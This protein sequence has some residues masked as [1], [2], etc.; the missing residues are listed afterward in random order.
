MTSPC[1][2]MRGGIWSLIKKGA[3][4]STTGT[5]TGTE[6]A[7]RDAMAGAG[8]TTPITA[9]AEI[10]MAM[11]LNPR[12]GEGREAT[13]A[14]EG[15]ATGTAT[16]ITMALLRRRPTM[17]EEEKKGPI[18]TTTPIGRQRRGT[19]RLQMVPREIGRGSVEEETVMGRGRD[20]A[21]ISKPSLQGMETT[22]RRTKLA[23][24][25]TGKT[26]LKLLI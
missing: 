24:K 1:G 8:G 26:N 14:T 3:P 5:G 20:T 23:P 16:T 6:R 7:G 18:A 13:A 2:P 10:T 17:C 12:R 22:S 25:V 9:G 19:A 4:G 21:L 11:V 15:R